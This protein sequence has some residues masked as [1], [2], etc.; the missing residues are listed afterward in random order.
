[1]NVSAQKT[2]DR[3]RTDSPTVSLLGLTNF[4]KGLAIAWIFAFHYQYSTGLSWFSWAGW[5]GV[6][7]FIVLSGFGVTY[8]C[9]RKSQKMDWQMWLRKRFKRILPTYWVATLLGCAVMLLIQYFTSPNPVIGIREALW[10][11]FLDITLLRD[12]SHQ[13]ITP[14]QNVSLW[15]VPFILG[16]YLLFPWLYPQVAKIRTLKG[17]LIFLGMLLLVEC[18]YRF[19]AVQWFNAAPIAYGALNLLS[20]QVSFNPNLW[21]FQLQAPFSIPLSRLAEFGLGMLLAVAIVR[22]AERTHQLILNPLA[23]VFG[24]VVWALG[25]AL[26]YAGPAGW[27]ISDFV[28]AVG[29]NLWLVNLARAVQTL[30]F[31]SFSIISKLGIWSYSIFLCHAIFI[32]LFHQSLEPIW[33]EQLTA[34]GSPLVAWLPL[35]ILI[36]S[37][38]MTAL[39]SGLLLKIETLGDSLILTRN[40]NPQRMEGE[41][42]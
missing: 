31:R 36:A 21:P 40:S 2:V 42:R 9:L 6:H 22:D 29:L 16:F 13:T 3:P 5:Q 7:L 24:L 30:S 32:H 17:G 10:Q 12:F 33:A 15:F 14:L 27:V 20:P 4:C 34:S 37:V 18:A 41:I 39:V 23:A 11:T 25:I 35:I 26:V 8:A 1:M 19:A 38:G 28:I